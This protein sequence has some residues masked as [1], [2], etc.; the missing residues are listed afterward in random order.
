MN[1]KANPY[2]IENYTLYF[3]VRVEDKEVHFELRGGE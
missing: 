2:S 3:L 1:E